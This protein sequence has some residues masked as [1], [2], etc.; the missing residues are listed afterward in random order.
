M[1]IKHRGKHLFKFHIILCNVLALEVYTSRAYVLLRFSSLLV[2]K[3]ACNSVKFSDNF[4]I[5]PFYYY[6]YLRETWFNTRL[7]IYII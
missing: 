1:E 4:Q 7:K 3:F 2:C 6:L 5:F